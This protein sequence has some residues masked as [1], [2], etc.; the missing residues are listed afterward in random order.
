MKSPSTAPNYPPSAIAA[1]WKVNQPKVYDVTTVPIPSDSVLVEVLEGMPDQWAWNFVAPTPSERYT[2]DTLAFAELPKKYTSHG[3]ID[4]RSSPFIL[5][6]FAFAVAGRQATTAPPLANAARLYIDNQLIVEN[7]FPSGKTDGHNPFVPVASAIRAAFAPC[8]Q[9]PRGGRR[10]RSSSGNAPAP[11]GAVR[12]RKKHRPEVGETSV[13]LAPAGTDDFWVIGS[14]DRK[15]VESRPTPIAAFPLVDQAWLAWE[16]QERGQIAR[17][18]PTA[19]RDGRQAPTPT[20]GSGVTPGPAILSP[21][22]PR[23]RTF[24]RPIHCGPSRRR[25]L[26]APLRD[27]AFVRRITPSF[28]AF[29]SIAWACLPRRNKWLHSSATRAP[30]SGVT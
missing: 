16:R 5:G 14:P 13:S 7:P 18:Q 28:A 30:T 24:D 11:P 15:T 25:A 2:Q 22:S 3:V 23:Y 26:R 12:R 6:P 19:P 10:C 4:D 9:A 1:R 17:D 27:H 29:I 8:S 21:R 20:T